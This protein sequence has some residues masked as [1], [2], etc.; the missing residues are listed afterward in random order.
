MQIYKQH[1]NPAEYSLE[2]ISKP[3][4]NTDRQYLKES[5]NLYLFQFQVNDGLQMP[6]AIYNLMGVI[7]YQTCQ[8]REAL[9]SFENAISTD[10]DSLNA[11][12]HCAVMYD[13][14]CREQDASDARAKIQ[15]VRICF[16][17]DK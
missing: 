8:M 15:E 17:L 1:V 4:D 9:R 12:E 10:K 7:L 5:S 6:T 11:L 3:P 13:K 2:I 16:V 14:M